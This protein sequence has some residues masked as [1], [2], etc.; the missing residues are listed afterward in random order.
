MKQKEFALSKKINIAEKFG[1]FSEFWSP[2]IVA[3]LNDQYIKFAKFKDEFVWHQHDDEDELFIVVEGEIEIRF[4][5]GNVHLAK[6][7][8]LVVPK[9]VRHC[10]VA[11]TD[12][13]HVLLIEPKATQ[14]TGADVTGKTIAVENQEWI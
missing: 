14:Q 4:E 5:D 3:E 1:K 12:E 7:E 13:A 10:P 2:K 6:G 11:L 8:M 9:G